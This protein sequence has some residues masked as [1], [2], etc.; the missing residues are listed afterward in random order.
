M[1]SRLYEILLDY[2][3]GDF[4]K[5]VFKA[6]GDIYPGKISMD[7]Y[8]DSDGVPGILEGVVMRSWCNPAVHDSDCEASGGSV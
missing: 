8:A 5:R 2:K 6:D 1:S 3:T 7:D 4:E